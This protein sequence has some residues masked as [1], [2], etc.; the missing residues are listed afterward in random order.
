VPDLRIGYRPFPEQQ[1]YFRRKVNMPSARWDDLMH[2]EHAHGFMAAGVARAD[3][4]EDLRQAVQAAIDDGEG[5]EAFRER[6]EAIVAAKGWIGGAGDESDARRA[7]RMRTIYHTN[8]RTSY[9]AGRWEELQKFPYL[10][11]QHNT[12]TNP[13]HEHEAWDGK[14]IA[15]DDPWWD[16][17]YP[18]NG[19][20][21]RCTVTGVG[22]GRLAALGGP[23]QAPPPGDGDPPPEWASHPGKA[24]RS[25][26]AAESFGRKVMALPPEWRKIALDDAQQRNVQWFADWPGFV[27]RVGEEIAR[28]ATRPQ[29]ASTPLGLLPSNVVDTLALGR[30]LDGR[31]FAAVAPQSALVATTDRAVYHALRDAKFVDRPQL[32]EVFADAL[33]SAPE[34]VASADAVLWDPANQVLLFAR[35][36]EAGR[37]MTLVTRI[38]RR[39]KR[40]R[41]PAVAAWVR[42]IETYSAEVL[43]RYVRVAGELR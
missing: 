9:M 34:W 4:L 1:A 8:L 23:D 40:A 25:L 29:G 16:T 18:P 43:R 26:P 22:K 14:I 42:T 39:E 36:D 20:G 13:R 33:R 24:A 12:V 30:G 28:G 19:W 11:Y 5:F 3:V 17:H 21:C 38:D 27:D 10:R 2:G 32:R 31:A 6:F 37:Y 15:R 41:E 35:R 7:W